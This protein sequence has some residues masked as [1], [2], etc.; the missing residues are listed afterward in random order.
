MASWAN[1]A[2]DLSG[3]LNNIMENAM[4]TRAVLVFPEIRPEDIQTEEVKASKPGIAGAVSVQRV[5]VMGTVQKNFSGLA[6][7]MN[8]AAQGLTGLKEQLKMNQFSAKSYTVQFNPSN[9]QIRSVGGGYFA[10]TDYGTEKPGDTTVERKG[11]APHI[12]I[13]FRIIVDETNNADAFM[14]DK[15]SLSPSGTVQNLGTLAATA[16][17]KKEFTVRPQVE[18]FLG[19]IRSDYHRAVILQWGKLRYAG[20]L[21]SVQ[22]RYTMFSPSGNPIRAEIDITLQAAS[23]ENE[24]MMAFWKKRYTDILNNLSKKQKDG[25]VSAAA[26]NLT[27]TFSNLLNI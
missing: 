19:A 12:T 5:N 1:I 26:G 4:V 20:M 15:F 9:L 8:Q 16:A 6:D 13:S 24:A 3:S 7:A 23:T 17:G 25:T 2:S 11:M 18:G 22:T 14:T 10:V 27:N 21:N